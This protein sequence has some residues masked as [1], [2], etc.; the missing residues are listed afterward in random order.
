MKSLKEVVFSNVPHFEKTA[1]YKLPQDAAEWEEEIIKK[2]SEDFSGLPEDIHRDIVINYVDES[3]GYAK[4]SV[5]LWRNPNVRVNIPIIIDQYKLSP[6]DVMVTHKEGGK[7]D[8]DNA[9]VKNISQAL[10]DNSIGEIDRTD[11]TSKRDLKSPGGVTPKQ[12]KTYTSGLAKVAFETAPVSM[13]EKVGKKIFGNR[14]IYGAFATNTGDL[15]KHFISDGINTLKKNPARV[16]V[17][18]PF[19]KHN[20]I[21]SM[22]SLALIDSKM[23]PIDSL[24]P[25]NNGAVEIRIMRTKDPVEDMIQSGKPTDEMYNGYPLNG[26]VAVRYDYNKQDDGDCRYCAFFSED[27][28][29]WHDGE[30]S[31]KNYYATPLLDNVC[32]ADKVLLNLKNVSESEM[33]E[34]YRK[35][36]NNYSDCCLEANEPCNKNLTD[37]MKNVKQMQKDVTP[38]VLYRNSDGVIVY[39]KLERDTYKPI[40]VN[41]ETAFI[42][43]SNIIMHGAVK[44]IIEAKETRDP[45]VNM[46][47]DN[48]KVIVIPKEA[49]VVFPECMERLDSDDII[50]PD[51]DIKKIYDEIYDYKYK[52]N[53]SVN[54]KTGKVS[55]E[56]GNKES[57]PTITKIAG[58]DHRNMDFKSA[59]NTIRIMGMEKKAAYE[60]LESAVSKG[61]VT[62]FGLGDNYINE[63]YAGYRKK[64]K[65]LE[66]FL[67]KAAEQMRPDF[68]KQASVLNNK[69]AVENVLATNFIDKSNLLEF[70]KNI[71]VLEETRKLVAKLLIASRMG[72][73]DIDESAAKEVMEGLNTLIDQLRYVKAIVDHAEVEE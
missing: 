2:F 50:E 58:M 13:F 44:S 16:S 40:T 48:R 73:S 10:D 17:E 6:F 63:K 8:F 71:D 39:K 26:I 24:V 69:E 5:V 12:H 70:V 34:G 54:K 42:S 37:T 31:K 45:A 72:L 4:G 64:I 20:T 14:D 68:I 41:G 38:S 19:D 56:L 36:F 65:N 15:I 66:L 46:I 57:S 11:P 47:A 55:I 28:S 59:Y 35:R 53:I 25:I 51:T 23:V 30:Y 61:R 52:V 67:E 32:V 18:M 1:N 27:G 29:F 62:V 7:P 49:A 22:K 60:A 33:I 43:K 21:Q 3:N 9:T